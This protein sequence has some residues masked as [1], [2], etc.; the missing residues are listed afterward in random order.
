MAKTGL[1]YPVAALLDGELKHG[2]LPKYKEGF[3][4]GRAIT[5]NITPNYGENPLYA[6]NREVDNDT[7]LIDGGLS[8]NVDEL[9]ETHKEAFE[10]EQKLLGGE[11]TGEEEGGTI[12]MHSGSAVNSNY[13]GFGRIKIGRYPDGGGTYYEAEW[14]YLAKFKPGSET[15]S[16]KAASTTWQTPT[17]EGKFYPVPGVDTKKN[18]KKKARFSSEKEAVAWINAIAGI[19]TESSTET[20]SGNSTDI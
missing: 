6:D 1:F 16:T 15:D 9:G 13:L 7:D 5:A 20:T 17:I 14:F 19:S 18:V 10:T 8:L 12:E 4:I 2:E 11:V 3:V